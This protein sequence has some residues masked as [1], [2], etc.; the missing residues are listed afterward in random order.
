MVTFPDVPLGIF[1]FCMCVIA[2][3]SVQVGTW[4]M[5]CVCYGVCRLGA[6]ILI[7]ISGRGL[8]HNCTWMW[9]TQGPTV[10]E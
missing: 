5:M 9:H 7:Y 1:L 8:T 10:S 3:G 2:I 4:D 6:N